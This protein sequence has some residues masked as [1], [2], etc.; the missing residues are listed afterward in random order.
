MDIV[1][2][3]VLF[4]QRMLLAAYSRHIRQRANSQDSGTCIQGVV[5]DYSLITLIQTLNQEMHKNQRWG[6]MQLCHSFGSLRKTRFR[7]ELASRHVLGQQC[8]KHGEQIC[9]LWTAEILDTSHSVLLR[10]AACI[11]ILD[12]LQE[13]AE[14]LI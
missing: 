9:M 4:T 7:L 2:E 11:E 10:Q 8:L 12:C 1:L 13:L 14:C 5:T 3:A 6:C